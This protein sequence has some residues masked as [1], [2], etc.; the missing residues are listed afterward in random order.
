MEKI[1]QKAIEGGYNN[2]A[3]RDLLEDFAKKIYARYDTYC[4]I[5][6]DPLFWQAL[7]KACGWVGV[8]MAMSGG[9]SKVVD[10][11]WQQNALEFHK[12]NLYEGWNKAISYLESIIN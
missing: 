9:H 5:V 8:E 10:T 7:G 11:E 12:I 2:D 3:T 1:I 6:C 4:I